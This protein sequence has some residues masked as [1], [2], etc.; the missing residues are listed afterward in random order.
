MIKVTEEVVYRN[1]EGLGQSIC[2][3]Q[4]DVGEEM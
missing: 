4:K 2:R 1:R 3:I